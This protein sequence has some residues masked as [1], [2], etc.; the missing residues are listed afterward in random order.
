M[1]YKIAKETLLKEEGPHLVQRSA[2]KTRR[3]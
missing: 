2:R 3:E 1:T